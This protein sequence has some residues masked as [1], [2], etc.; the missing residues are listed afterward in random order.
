MSPLYRDRLVG[1]NNISLRFTVTT[2]QPQQQ[3]HPELRLYSRLQV[4][5]YTHSQL[6]T[7]AFVDL[8]IFYYQLSIS[9]ITV[10]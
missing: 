9:I 2:T 7:C 1:N 6:I 3:T 8:I 4:F 5:R 10:Q